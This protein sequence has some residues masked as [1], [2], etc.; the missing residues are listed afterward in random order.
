MSRLPRRPPEERSGGTPLLVWAIY[1]LGIL[2]VAVF[3]F[4]GLFMLGAY[5]A[6]ED[7]PV[8]YDVSTPALVLWGGLAALALATFLRRRRR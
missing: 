5:L 3:V 1:A 4:S 7:V 6:S 2:A 8:T